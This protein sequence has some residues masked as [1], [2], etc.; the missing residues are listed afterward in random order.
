MTH[1][2]NNSLVLLWFLIQYCPVTWVYES[3][4]ASKSWS[5]LFCL[6]LFLYPNDLWLCIQK[7]LSSLSIHSESNNVIHMY[8]CI[9][10]PT[11]LWFPNK[12]A[13]TLLMETHFQWWAHMKQAKNLT[14]VLNKL[15]YNWLKTIK[16][17]TTESDT[18]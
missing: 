15:F 8:T 10:I 4:H 1:S 12:V 2:W 14:K 5:K 13:L 7:Q 16:V 9:I 3:K 17:E 11:F 6:V 18:D